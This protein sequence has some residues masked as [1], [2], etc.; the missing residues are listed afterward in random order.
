MLERLR[1][2]VG[3]IALA[4]CLAFGFGFAV[5]TSNDPQRPTGAQSN[6]YPQNIT[7]RTDQDKTDRDWL[8]RDATGLFTAL[9]FVVAGIQ[10]ILFLVQ[11][12]LIRESLD[13]AKAA[14][15][16]AYRAI[17]EAE[18]RDKILQRAYLWP[19]YGLLILDQQTVRFGIHLGIRNTGRTAGIIKTVHHALLS[20][21]EFEANNSITYYVFNGREDA[22]IPDPNMEVRSGVWHR[23]SEM[24]KISCG[25]ITYIDVFGIKRC[26]GYKYIIDRRGRTESLPG[27]FTYEPWNSEHKEKPSEQEPLPAGFITVPIKSGETA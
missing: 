19:G 20:K 21:E 10:A 1:S 25:W 26:R 8:T 7:A 12:K 9:L 13:P 24:P 3:I 6:Q 5:W 27:C 14:A 22:I 17:D 23:L 11:L 16:A 18:K 15:N 2:N 4:A